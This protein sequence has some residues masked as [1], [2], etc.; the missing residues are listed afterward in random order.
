MSPAAALI[1]VAYRRPESL[2]RVLG[3]VDAD[4]H[5]VVVN[6][7]ADERV[8]E[9]AARH[10]ADLTLAVG[11]RGYAAAVNAGVDRL[12]RNID[13]VVFSND[14]VEFAPE[15]LHR[16]MTHV[17][18]RS[19]AVALPAIVDSGGERQRTL[20]PRVTLLSLLIQWALLPDRPPQWLGDHVPITR[21]RLPEQTEVVPGG[22]G[23]VVAASRA[24]IERHPLPEEYF[25]YWEERE[26]FDVIS[27]TSAVVSY[28]PGAVVRHEGGRGDVRAEKQRLIVRNAILC[29]R[30]QHGVVAA[31]VAW[32]IV[33][34]WQ[35]RLSVQ[36]AALVLLRRR[37]TSELAVR[38]VGLLHAISAVRG[39]GGSTH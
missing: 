38:L 3:S 30:R 37:P 8:A 20:A 31:V 4:V 23:T 7:D 21:W 22:T 14:D 15:A 5:L 6:V 28:L 10:G 33:I 11:N 24:L 1:V 36:T 13:V 35:V 2:E 18:P 17:R 27:Q 32:P 39:L 19:C 12:P 16:L 29:V 26:W 34:L 25:M 9:V